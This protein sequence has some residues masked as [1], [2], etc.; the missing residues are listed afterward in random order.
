MICEIT[1]G[2]GERV[3][4][5]HELPLQLGDWVIFEAQQVHLQK[6]QEIGKVTKLIKSGKLSTQLE[7]APLIRKATQQDM[8]EYKKIKEDELRTFEFCKEKVKDFGFP[9]KVVTVHIQFDRTLTKIDFL[10]EKKIDLKPLIK[11]LT[12]VQ[13]GR[14]ELHQ[15]GI[16]DYAKRFHAYG[17]CGRPVC[18]DSFLTEFEPITLDF[19]KLQHLS[20][21]TSKLT[22]V[23]GRLVCCLAY[24]RK[25]YK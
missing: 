2:E 9:I 1:F 8:D 13:K 21:G 22:G 12:K 10:G 7:V 19:V 24:E 14:I 5:T 15:I 20:C 18:C 17:V 6:G 11:E 16:R 3:G 23:C 25:L 4:A